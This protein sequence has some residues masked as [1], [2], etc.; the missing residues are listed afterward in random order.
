MSNNFASANTAINEIVKAV[1]FEFVHDQAINNAA[2]GIQAIMTDSEKDFIVGGKVKPYPSGGMNFI[3]SPIYGHCAGSGV[4]FIETLTTPQAISI[5]DA[6]PVYD[7]ID[8]VQVRGKVVPYDFQDRRFRDPTSGVETVENIPTKKRIAM[9]VT[10]KKGA[11]GSVTAPTADVGYIKLAE[12]VVPAASVSISLEN[13]KNITAR[14]VGAQNANWTM[15]KTRTFNSGYVS[16]IVA[17]LLANHNEDGSHK[18]NIITAANILFGNQAG[19]VRGLAIPTGES[20]KVLDTDYNAVSSITAVLAALGL[21]VNKA[22]P[23]ANNLL[24]RYAILD[25]HPVAVS[26]ENVD[27]TAGGE[28]TIDGIPCTVGQMVF[29]KDQEDPIENGFY[30]VQTGAWNRFVGFTAA[31]AGI[32]THKFILAKSGD[33]NEGRMF[34][35]DGDTYVIGTTPLEFKVSF[36]SPAAIPNTAVFRNEE[37]KTDLDEKLSNADMVP[38]LGR[39]LLDVLKVS[40]IPEAMAELRRRC[41][42]N[43]EIDD[44]RIPD[45]RGL[46]VGDYLDG[47]DFTGITAPSTTVAL[48]GG[49]QPWNNTYKNNRIVIGGFNTYK[50]SGDTENTDNHILFVFRDVLWQQRQRPANDN[51]GGY[52]SSA[53]EIRPYLEG[54]NGDGNGIFA[55][56]LEE[57]LNGGVLPPGGKYLY[58]IRKAHS[59]KGGYAWANY[60]V[61]LPT[62]IEVHGFQTYGDELNQYNTNV[63]FPI[64]QKSIEHRCKKRNGARAWW[65]EGTPAASDSTHF[66]AV[67]NLGYAYHNY[68]SFTGGGVSPAFCVR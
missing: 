34:Y 39:N 37:G 2:L 14:S 35:L 32:F 31:N 3:I 28:T 55:L 4:D 33:V 60:T 11:D 49:P 20:M 1:D 19:A 42:N 13:I 36:F 58:T 21:A 24:S 40:T 29:L 68:A 8:T 16:E 51:A 7:R 64:F 9:E 17:A 45:F 62:E 56:K 65:W 67:H 15:D 53:S 66:C 10:V 27:I 41:N 26:T 59:T 12:I 22:Y 50:Q 43:G 63:Q 54:A 5:E 57:L 44:T 38:G 18:D 46:M 25:A 61:W 6:S 30:E 48:N 23:Y 47:L 52:T